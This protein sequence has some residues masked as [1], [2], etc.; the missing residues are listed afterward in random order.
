MK[1]VSFS[2]LFAHTRIFLHANVFIYTFLFQTQTTANGLH[3]L[4]KN[5]FK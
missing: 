5:A 4:G 3:L 2:G 1:N